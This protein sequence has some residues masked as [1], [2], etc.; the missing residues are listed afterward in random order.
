MSAGLLRSEGIL[1]FLLCCTLGRGTAVASDAAMQNQE[2]VPIVSAVA[3]VLPGA[4]PSRPGSAAA[5]L[6]AAR[7]ARRSFAADAAPSIDKLMDEFIDALAK[8][9]EKALTKLRVTKSE[10]V[11]LIVPGTVPVGQPPRVVSDQPREYYWG[12]LDTKSHYYTDNLVK[13]FGGRTYRSRELKFSRPPK[14][15]AWYKAV[16]Q[17]RLEL[18]GDDDKSYHLLTGWLAEIDGKYKFISYEYND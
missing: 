4:T 8:K 5:V 15:Y 1:V 7:V 12:L 11:D 3:G 6:A 16:G 14:E 18:Q 9:D 2:S 17:V 13:Q 10:Y